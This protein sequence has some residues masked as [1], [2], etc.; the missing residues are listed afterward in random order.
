MRTKFKSWAEPFLKEHMEV[1]L[2]KIDGFYSFDNLFLEIGS[3]KGDFLVNMAKSNPDL[4]FLGLEKNVTCAG[5]T[6]K[7]LVENELTNAKLVWDD[8][9]NLLPHLKKE[10]VAV[11]FLNFSDPWPKKRHTKRRLTS[12]QFLDE[13]KRVLKKDGCIIFKT[14]NIDLFNYSLESF[15]ENGFKIL[16]KTNDYL[17]DDPF[18][19]VT[20]YEAKF[21]KMGTPINRMVVGK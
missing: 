19:S 11:I 1:Q 8:A 21:R 20:E 6:A 4:L 14:D 9:A 13:Y 3:G 18:D 15:P 16:E 5:F 12:E 17:G 7:K 2:E 10:S